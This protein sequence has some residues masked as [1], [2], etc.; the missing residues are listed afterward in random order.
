MSEDTR[1][2]LTLDTGQSPEAVAKLRTEIQQLRDLLTL[3]AQDYAHGN[4]P[5]DEFIEK[6]HQ[7][8][9]AISELE[10]AVKTLTPPDE[11]SGFAGV[12]TNIRKA[13]IALN[14]L[15]TGQGLG[16]AGP[17]LESVLG[18]LGGPA[19][20][21]M[22]IGALALAV[23]KYLPKI[24]AFFD[25]FDAKKIEA[26]TEAT[27]KLIA[28]TE[29][30]QA[31]KQDSAGK[32]MQDYYPG[33]D[34]AGMA[35]GALGVS[36]LGEQAT[37]EELAAI[38]GQEGL[39]R[40]APNSA[41]A[42]AELQRLQD[43]LANRIQTANLNRARSLVDASV[44]PGA[45]G[46]RARAM[47]KGLAQQNPGAF[48]PEFGQ[49]LEDLEPANQAAARQAD[50][51]LDEA[52]ADRLGAKQAGFDAAKAANQKNRETDQAVD[53]AQRMADDIGRAQQQAAQRAQRAAQQQQAK[54]ARDAERSARENTPQAQLRREQQAAEGQMGALALQQWNASGRQESPEFV[55]KA[56][57]DAVNMLPQ[58]NGDYA[59][60]L[61]QA[62][63]AGYQ[64]AMM[65][66]QRDMA[67]AAV[68]SE[69]F[70]PG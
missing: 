51:D 10:T 19:G 28:A 35:A 33:H 4:M 56:I 39:V 50:L 59:Q 52:E 6:T 54:A 27:N 8:R 40:F 64:R 36:G 53:L 31:L 23:E 9:S 41:P 48:P 1:I 44:K 15:V 7:A 22:A 43:A 45:E 58:T 46:E 24:E 57:H 34:V 55:Q 65:Q 70:Y 49:F 42:K 20:M 30:L 12:A 13:E 62:V 38:Q 16:R 18:A 60:A 3:L 32:A 17:M 63:A 66:Q 47:L 5:A 61:A 26:A 25:V 21:G 2:Q 14:S 29:K 67:R 68:F 37:P 69:S 11:D